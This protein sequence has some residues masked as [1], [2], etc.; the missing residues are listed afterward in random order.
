MKQ[1]LPHSN[2]LNNV[3]A[4]TLFLILAIAVLAASP[5]VV[6]Q[7]AEL[8]PIPDLNG[9]ADAGSPQAGEMSSAAPN[10]LAPERDSTNDI[11][12]NADMLQQLLLEL[13]KEVQPEAES[14][15]KHFE[16]NDQKL[17]TKI[18]DFRELQIR[19]RNEISRTPATAIR[20]REIRNEVWELMSDQ[21]TTALD[22]MRY[23]PSSES[24]S[25]LITMVQYHYSNDI[26][27]AETFEAAARLLELGQSYKFLF[28]SAARS[29]IVTGNFDS[30]RQIYKSLKDED[31]EDVDRKLS[32][33]MDELEKE[34]AEEQAAIAATDPDKLPRVRFETTMGN[35]T[36]ELFTDS[37]PSAVA[38]FLK[39]NEDHF[40]D[41]S[42]WSVV[43]DNVLALTGDVSG[44]GR[45][46]SGEFLIDEHENENA[47]NVL[48]GS[49][50]MAKIPINQGQFI[51]NSGSSQ[52]AIALLPL[53]SV[54]NSQTVFGRVVE[55][56]DVVSRLRRVDP[57]KE[58]KQNEVTLP[59]DSITTTEIIRP[60]VDLPD[61][62][63]VDVQKELEKAVKAGLIRKKPTIPTNENP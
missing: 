61:P 40:Y 59:P 57:T 63:Y 49:L 10:L 35:F 18:G 26:Y 4:R 12:D 30:A 56:M 48:R 11:R 39:L 52:F 16:E 19:S 44:D 27:D 15:W 7:Q 31:L 62:K 51:P 14:V 32:F 54:K 3:M 43:T 17:A 55:G 37:A 1:I 42:D 20:Y 33:Q 41:G 5:V 58:K 22:L 45:G 28:Q 38:H 47:R 2:D 50:I 36:V 21:F 13:P 6:A 23:L 60:A 9:N 29:A 46:N 24:A 34:Y 25:Y 53:I 8:P